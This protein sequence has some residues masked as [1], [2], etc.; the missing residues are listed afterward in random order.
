MTSL[1]AVLLQHNQ[2]VDLV[3]FDRPLLATIPSRP[4]VALP[5]GAYEEKQ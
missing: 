2:P 5:A 1:E 3:S 4:W